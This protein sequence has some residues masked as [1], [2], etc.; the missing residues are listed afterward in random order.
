MESMSKTDKTI[1]NHKM[2]IIIHNNEKGTCMLIDVAISWDRHVNEKEA[3]K[4]LKYKDLIIEIQCMWIVKEK[5][6]PVIMGATGT[7]S[8]SF[9]QYLSKIL[10][11][12]KI[13]ALPKTAILGT[14]SHTSASTNITGQNIFRMQNNIACST[15]CKYRTAATLYTLNTWFQIYN[16]RYRVITRMMMMMMMMIIIIIISRLCQQHD[17]TIDLIISACPILAKEH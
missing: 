17:E 15:N 1:P 6:T 13:K 7:I 14:A 10:G 12:C 5:V 11:K 16:C 3:K 9:R 2:D 8:K 4:I